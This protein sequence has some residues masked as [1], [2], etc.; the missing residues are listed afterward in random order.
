MTCLN[1]ISLAFYYNCT[2]CMG[3]TLLISFDYY[4]DNT[5]GQQRVSI[6]PL[7]CGTEI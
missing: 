4:Y 5:C 7:A 1:K 6:T 3:M 2:P